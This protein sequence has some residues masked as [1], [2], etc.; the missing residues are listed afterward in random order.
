ME[1]ALQ[2]RNSLY[3]SPNIVRMIKSIRLKRIGHVVRMEAG[4]SDIKIL[5]IISEGD[6]FEGDNI[7]IDE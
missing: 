6:Y 5:C 2:G 3:L 1:K 4:K 7:D